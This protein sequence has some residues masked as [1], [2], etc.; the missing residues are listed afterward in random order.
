MVIEGWGVVGRVLHDDHHRHDGRLPRSP[1]AVA[2]RPG[3]HRRR[4]SFGGVGAALYTFTLLATVVVEGGLP[5]RLQ[6]RRHERMLETIKDHF[7]ICGYGRIGS[8][9]ARPV[10]AAGRAVRRHRARPG[11]AAGGDRG[12]RARRRGR[13][14]PRGRAEAR[15]HR[16]RA[17]PDRGGRHRRRERLRRAERAR[18]AAGSVHRRPRGDRGRDAEAEARRRRSRHLAVP[19]RRACRWRRRRCGRRSSTSWSW[20]PAPTTSS[21]RWSRSRSRRRR[22]WPTSRSSRRTCGSGSA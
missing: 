11:A 20:R 15:R 9:V 10:P 8:I 13:R 6:R 17:R 5:K 18:A 2:R 3:L 7:I 21:W 12:R 16:P 19:D 14:Q 4:C 1:P 22:R